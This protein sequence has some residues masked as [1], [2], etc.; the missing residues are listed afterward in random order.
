MSP[1]GGWVCFG[2]T[3]VYVS[4]YRY[5]PTRSA[6]RYVYSDRC[7]DVIYCHVL[8]IYLYTGLVLICITEVDFI[9][10]WYARKVAVRV[11]NVSCRV[12]FFPIFFVLYIV[13]RTVWLLP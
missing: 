2:L 13:H 7:L 8:F 6:V 5:V 4:R 11:N 10:S 3:D 9:L 1:C 12:V